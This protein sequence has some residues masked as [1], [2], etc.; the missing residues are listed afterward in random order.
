MTPG[1]ARRGGAG[2]VIRTAFANSPFGRLLVGTTDKGVCF[3][4]FAEP[5]AALLGDLR[6][7][8]PHAEMVATTPP[9]GRP[10]LRCC[11]SSRNRA[12][13][14]TCRW[15]SRYR[16]FS[17]GSGRRCARFPRAKRAAM[18]NWPRCWAIRARCGRWPGPAPPTRC[19]WPCRAT[20]LSAGRRPDGLPVGRTAQTGAAGTGKGGQLAPASPLPQ[21]GKVGWRS[22]S[23][24]GPRA[25][26]PH[27]PRFRAAPLPLTG[28]VRKNGL[29]TRL[30][31][32]SILHYMVKY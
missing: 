28:E 19:R 21:R 30:P 22:K 8:F 11:G 10:L 14:W 29:T 5:D 13:H 18:A 27:P 4:G 9:W 32:V 17:N 24:E 31:P 12:R 15:I 3:I 16:R 1:A 20:A 25:A 2:E 23:G 7:R 6:R 26:C